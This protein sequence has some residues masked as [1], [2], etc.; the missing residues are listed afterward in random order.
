[1]SQNVLLI[2][3]I[4]EE[5]A[6][7]R[8]I[9]NGGSDGPA[10][11][12]VAYS[13]TVNPTNTALWGTI[14]RL[15]GGTAF[16]VCDT[17]GYYRCGSTCTWIVP[18]GV[19]VAQFQLWGAGAG[20]GAGCCCAGSPFGSTGAYSIA[21][22][23]VSPGAT[24]SITSGCAY[25]CCSSSSGGA[26]S[27]G[28]CPSFV[29]GPNITTLCAPG[30]FASGLEGMYCAMMDYKGLSNL[31]CCRFSNIGFP[32]GG[33]CICG[34]G[35]YCH[36]SCATCG[37][38]PIIPSFSRYGVV[39]VVGGWGTSLPSFHGGGCNTTDNYGYH[40]SPPVI[41]E[42]HGI[43]TG[44]DCCATYTSG[45]CCGGWN[46]SAINGNRQHPGSGGS[47]THM[48]GGNN[49]HFGD[50]GRMGMVRVTYC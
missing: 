9:V 49:T 26:I 38:I 14:P 4:L 39:N 25:C 50:Q 16:N 46:C 5:A 48:M 2:N 18:A 28:G 31:S 42:T 30:A 11:T 10:E 8:S 6:R 19:S 44:S 29:T 23:P 47:H 33:G 7:L 34:N 15:T 43:F 13:W 21:I 45:S 17:S 27:A 36:S 22:I 24:Y 37:E 3:A 12:C 35:S 20:T 40:L 41:S 32:A 1:M